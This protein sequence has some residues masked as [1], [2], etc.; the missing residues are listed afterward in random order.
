MISSTTGTSQQ[1]VHLFLIIILYA[2]HMSLVYCF[3]V[4]STWNTRDVFVGLHVT[5]MSFCVTQMP[6]ICYSYV[7]HMPFVRT[8]MFMFMFMCTLFGFG[9]I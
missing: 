8:R 5:R 4:V 7:I 1:H 2:I 3:H 6:F 9:V